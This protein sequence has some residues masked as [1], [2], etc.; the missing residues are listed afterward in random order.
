L[1]G[2]VFQERCGSQ[3]EPQRFIMY[4]NGYEFG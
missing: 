1:I 2:K 3:H 4:G